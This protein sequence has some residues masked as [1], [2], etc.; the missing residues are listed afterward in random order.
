MFTLVDGSSRMPVVSTTGLPKSAE[1]YHDEN[2]VKSSESDDS[3]FHAYLSS[4]TASQQQ[5]AK[6]SPSSSRS[7]LTQKHQSSKEIHSASSKE[8]RS[9]SSA[10]SS[11]T[12]PVGDKAFS[13]EPKLHSATDS[14][15]K[16]QAAHSQLQPISIS[17][18]DDRQS[19]PESTNVVGLLLS[20]SADSV[21][22]TSSSEHR[23]TKF[24]ENVSFNAG[25]VSDTSV[26]LLVSGSN[27]V[28]TDDPSDDLKLDTSSSSGHFNSQLSS[29]ILCPEPDEL[30]GIVEDIQ[31]E[32]G[33]NDMAASDMW[34]SSTLEFPDVE[35][36]DVSM[37]TA[38]TDLAEQLGPGN[39][40]VDLQVDKCAADD[41]DR[42][43][44]NSDKDDVPYSIP[45]DISEADAK[46]VKEV[47]SLEGST[48][49]ISSLEGSMETS[50]DELSE[51]NKTVVADDADLYHDDTD[52]DEMQ[53]SGSARSGSQHSRPILSSELCDSYADGGDAVDKERGLS[54]GTGTECQV[55]KFSTT[56]GDDGHNSSEASPPSSSSVKNLLE[57]AIA[58]SGHCNSSDSVEPVRVE[59]GGNSGHTSADEVDTTTSSDIEII[60]HASSVNGR[61]ASTHSSRPIDISPSRHGNMAWNSR[62]SYGGQHRRSDSGSSAQSL[63]SR[64]DDEF[65]SPEADHGRDYLSRPSRDARKH[66]AK[67]D[68]G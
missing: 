47:P 22:E 18:S 56:Q 27:E 17:I 54:S 16:T 67:S 30:L 40:T 31:P 64:T 12:T 35:T 19:K 33:W 8:S 39:W 13:S 37:A 51:S 53:L 48:K 65:A 49:E 42:G 28:G 59:S 6:H 60:S 14:D 21:A 3:F 52:I 23:E 11:R 57:E 41:V 66:H 61:A 2:V 20:T 44:Q 5:E 15:R 45:Q 62:T 68:P 10:V 43:G 29:S 4:P 46:V 26:A 63:Q 55:A 24:N 25:I 32:S 38:A 9:L 1:P 36:G 58:D 7:P 34:L 50:A